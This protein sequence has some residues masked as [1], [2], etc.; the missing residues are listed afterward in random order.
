[1]AGGM[2]RRGFLGICGDAAAAWAA[3]ARPYNVLFL[4]VEDLQACLSSY[5][6]WW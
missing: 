6:N 5:G 4:A 3:P 1:M 2:N